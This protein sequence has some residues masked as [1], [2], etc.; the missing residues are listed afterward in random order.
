MVIL[1]GVTCS[2][3]FSRYTQSHDRLLKITDL[4]QQIKITDY[5]DYERLHWDYRPP[6]RDY[7]HVADPSDQGV[8][9]IAYQ[10]P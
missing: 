2:C 3:K 8:F 7:S 4:Y 5:K 10:Q 1:T 6:V 9:Q